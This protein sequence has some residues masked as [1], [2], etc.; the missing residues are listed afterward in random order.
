VTRGLPLRRAAA[1]LLVAATAVLLVVSATGLDRVRLFLKTSPW[2]LGLNSPV[3]RQFDARLFNL[4]RAPPDAAALGDGGPVDRVRLFDPMGLALDAAGA[5]F[6]SDRGRGGPGRVVWRLGPDG[7][8][9][10]V[11]G[12][13]RRGTTLYAAD[14]RSADLGSPQGVCLDAQGRVYF[15]DSYNHV[16]LR[17]ERSGALTRVAGTGRPGDRGDGELATAAGLNQPYDVRL[18]AR[19]NL[20]IAD[21][22]NHRIRRVDT[23]GVIRTVAGSGQP[24]YSGDGGPATAARLREPYGIFPDARY[25]LLVADSGNHAIRQVD[26][27]GTIRTIAGGAR[28]LSGDGGSAIEARFDSPQSLFVDSTGRIYVGD[29]H[30]HVIRVIDRTGVVRRVAGSGAV[31]FSSDGTAALLGALK[32]VE[33]LVVADGRLY[34]TEAAAGRV[35][36]IDADGRLRTLAG[37]GRA[38]RAAR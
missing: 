37:G 23:A 14:A 32:N 15:A 25:G 5:L 1:A 17:V 33:N 7:V 26:S 16:V 2:L 35:R 4:R 28:G 31:G 12:T 9:R 29:E 27:S 20:Y 3:L 38:G 6:V 30:N 19:G 22:G 34:F 21:V 13:G 24:G 11:A 10:V 18:D 36:S 8:A